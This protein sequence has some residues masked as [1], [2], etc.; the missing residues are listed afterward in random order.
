MILLWPMDLP[1]KFVDAVL[2]K[3]C[4]PEVA[5][6]RGPAASGQVPLPVFIDQGY[7]VISEAH[8]FLYDKFFFSRTSN[9]KRTINTYAEC[10]LSWFKYIELGGLDWREAG[11]TQIISYRNSMK[12]NTE[13]RRKA[14]SVSTINLRLSVISEY[15]LYYWRDLLSCNPDKAEILARKI[16][17]LDKVQL[18]LRQNKILPRA[19][20]KE[21][22]QQ[23]VSTL[24]G[25]HKLI[26]EWALTTGMR[27]SSILN[28][29]VND[30]ESVE[31][32]TSTKFLK[33]L[34]KGGKSQH[35]YIPSSLIEKTRAYIDT[36]RRLN[37]KRHGSSDKLFLN[38]LGETVSRSC[39]YK[40]FKRGCEATSIKSHPH[41]T[42][43]TFATYMQRRIDAASK[44]LGIDSIK[45]IQGLL[46]HASSLTTQSYLETIAI[47]NPDIL[48]L[49]DLNSKDLASS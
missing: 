1:D 49:L 31:A 44:R 19:L 8:D 18:R 30:F 10:L 45:I 16:Q 46:G 39:Y 9:P 24:R 33:I 5:S 17:K 47:N 37:E 7:S 34:A 14:L 43:T 40:S 13:C 2:V 25:V 4:L 28:I 6:A 12:G 23:L 15:Y 20:S 32:N 41:Q 35:V 26:L 36:E 29:S 48:E 27:T 22:C 21:A 3:C 11:V 42:R 38:K